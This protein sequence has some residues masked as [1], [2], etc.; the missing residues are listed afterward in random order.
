VA[1]SAAEL[2]W[3][4]ERGGYGLT[5][6]DAGGW[7]ACTWVLH[8]MYE[9]PS[10]PSEVTHDDL[11]RCGLIP[12]LIIGDVNVDEADG[13][14]VTGT[15]LGYVVHP[16]VEWR[17]LRWSELAARLGVSFGT[18]QEWPP[19][20]KWLPVSSFPVNIAPPPEGSLDEESWSALLRTLS[21]SSDAG[22]D[23]PCLAYYTP[24]AHG[25]FD[26]VTVM[27]GPLR[28]LAEIVED[29]EFRST[30][31]NIWPADRSWLVWTDWDLW[32]TKVSGSTDL[33]RRM[34]DEPALETV[35][36]QAH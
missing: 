11:R 9:N 32:G 5:G 34:Q 19:C 17:R 15:P 28:A 22:M 10:L 27:R 6:Y 3:L 1:D 16:G 8:A 20:R 33:V 26:N 25:D 23:T 4:E 30:P 35:H 36:W 31:S 18:Q 14:T 7:D 12:P 24:L 13:T 21:D 2:A 29:T